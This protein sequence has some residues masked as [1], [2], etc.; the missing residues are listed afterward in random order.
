MSQLI[1][2]HWW[3]V[4]PSS[5]LTTQPVS[6]TRLGERLVLWR[7]ADGLA[8]AA[9]AGCPHR[10]AD[11]GHG[12]V[13]DGVLVCRY[14]GFR[15]NGDGACVHMPCEG[16]T[17]SVPAGLQLAMRPTVEAHGFVWLCRGTPS[18]TVPWVPEAPIAGP[19]GQMTWNVPLSRVIEAMLDIHH[20]PF[21]H[22]RFTPHIPRL[23]PY[24]ARFD[25]DDILRSSGTLRRDGSE[26]G[27]RFEMNLAFPGALH[28]RASRRVNVAVVCTPITP[29]QTWIAFRFAVDVPIVGKLLA[30]ALLWAELRLIQPDDQRLLESSL[31]DGPRQFVRADKA[32]ALWHA[33]RRRQLPLVADAA[34]GQS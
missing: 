13:V 12:R 9:L 7:A 34:D 20:F 16:P 21:A 10:S 5:L 11:L 26:R 1:P 25:D 19:V 29:T 18:S 4:W 17:A 28:V 31:P 22:H 32:I 30:A 23:E 24:E 6:L 33:R 15:Y 3:A 2:H 8:K 27:Q 14:H